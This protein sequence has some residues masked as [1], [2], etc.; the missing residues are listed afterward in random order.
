MSSNKTILID[1]EDLKIKLNHRTSQKKKSTQKS[2]IEFKKP[3]KTIKYKKLLGLIRKKQKENYEE[4]INDKPKT[5]SLEIQT[6]KGEFE[7]S[8]A[9][10]NEIKNNHLTESLANNSKEIIPVKNDNLNGSLANIPKGIPFQQQRNNSHNQTIKSHYSPHENVNLE[11][12]SDIPIYE[13]ETFI[14]QPNIPTTGFKLLPSPNYGVLKNGKL[15]TYRQYMKTI[16]NRNSDILPDENIKA[17]LQLPS[18]LPEPKDN[19]SYRRA[20]T[21][22]KEKEIK[23]SKI[24]NLRSKIRYPKIKKTIRRTFNVGRSKYYSVVGVIINNK[25]IRDECSTKKYLLKQTPI[26]EVKKYLIRKGLI[27]IGSTAPNDVLRKMYESANMI[28]GEIQNHNTDILLHNY[29]NE[30]IL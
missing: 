28:C 6:P 15:P 16:S 26:G 4:L 19:D 13:P 8:M 1:P 9:F 24:H 18:T 22:V 30:E 5:Q 7:E 23:E 11:F 12:P 2:K 10:F 21:I 3:S 29:F 17:F 14:N 20:S 27:K 25:T